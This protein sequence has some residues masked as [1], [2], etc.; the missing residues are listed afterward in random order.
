MKKKVLIPVGIVVALLLVL[1]LIRLLKKEHHEINVETTKVTIGS[2]SNTITATGTLQA[3]KTVD[4]GTQVSGEIDKIYVDF[5]SHVKAGQL[6]ATIDQ[7]PLKL[8]M[9]SA[10]ASLENAK[11]QETLNEA[12]YKRIKA[13]YDKKLVAESDYDN[14]LY[15][16][17][18]S[19]AS[20]KTS[21]SNYDRAKINLDYAY[22]YSPIDGV[23]LERA[24]DEGQ[25]VAASF[26]TPTLFSIAHDLT[27][28]QVEAS[29]D[30]A[31]IGQVKVGQRV[32]F[33][34]DAFP[35]LNFTGEVT[36]VRLQPVVSSNVVTY[37]VIV[38]A[39]NPEMKLMPGMTANI[40]VYVKEATNVPVVASKALRFQPD[41]TLLRE[42]ML[43]KYPQTA[44][45]FEEYKGA[46][47]NKTG[48]GGNGWAGRSGNDGGNWA[49]GRGNGGGGW[50]G[51]GQQE[52]NPDMHRVW[53]KDSLGI[54]PVRIET[55]IDDEI[56]VQIISGLKKGE[57][58]VFALSSNS[59]APTGYNNQPSAPQSPFMPRRPSRNRR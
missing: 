6:L 56:N 34:V 41:F 51:S 11:A 28:M 30:E 53:V 40:T 54:H 32:S 52:E 4:V 20:V 44:K 42:Y 26:N 50:A 15:N 29:I 14:A 3:T 17:Q 33:T 49:S 35:D 59:S 22:I 23:V 16:Y 12:N 36:Q 27:Q 10:E 57:E 39:P 21:Q 47:G 43:E 19:E 24:V 46:W 38:K 8:A 18:T 37:T 13:L 58:V 48:N 45:K 7:R 1:L 9:S 25:T 31:D 5:N 55:G 2:V